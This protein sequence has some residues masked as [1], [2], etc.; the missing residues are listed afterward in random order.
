MNIP[1]NYCNNSIFPEHKKIHYAYMP[2]ETPDWMN[3]RIYPQF[4]DPQ[5]LYDGI[6]YVP[7]I[8]YRNPI[9]QDLTS[10]TTGKTQQQIYR[11]R[12]RVVN[13]GI[14]NTIRM[15][16]MQLDLAQPNLH[17][18]RPQWQTLTRK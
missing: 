18:A 13:K 9:D 1:P 8:I 6:T 10:Y 7:S 11:D 4:I 16:K 3:K 5:Q 2:T 12:V 14:D 15:N 17:Q